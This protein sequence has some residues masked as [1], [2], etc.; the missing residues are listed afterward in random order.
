MR[1]R[2][3]ARAFA[4]R[5]GIAPGDFHRSRQRTFRASLVTLLYIVLAEPVKR[6][7][8]SGIG[9]RIHLLQDAEAAPVLIFRFLIAAHLRIKVREIGESPGQVRVDG[10]N[11][12][13]VISNDRLYDSSAFAYLRCFW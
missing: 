8:D 3:G 2:P 1:A 12:R 4:D 11:R 13:S 7:R 5:A 10:P 6:L 9:N